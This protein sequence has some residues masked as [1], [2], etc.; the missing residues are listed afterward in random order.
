M[1]TRAPSQHVSVEEIRLSPEAEK[2]LSAACDLDIARRLL[3]A[4]PAHYV[5]LLIIVLSTPYYRDHP[6]LLTAFGIAI[7]VLTTTRMVLSALMPAHY[8]GNPQLWNTLIMAGIYVSGLLLSS[9]CFITLVYYQTQWTS[10]VL[11]VILSAVAAGSVSALTPKPR[12][13]RH[14]LLILLLPVISW[15]IA[16]GATE[17][18]AVSTFTSVF[19]AFL[20]LQSRAHCKTYRNDST[21]SFLLKTQAETVQ[22]TKEQLEKFIQQSLDPII[23]SDDTGHLIRVNRAF[24]DMIGCTEEEVIGKTTYDV[25]SVPEVGTYECTT[26]EKVTIDETYFTT[27]I[28]KI[29]QLFEDGVISNWISYYM[30]RFRKVV[31]V[32]QNIIFLYNEQGERTGAFS[33]IRNITEQRKAELE[34]IQAKEIA[35]KASQS[36]SNFLANM[37]HEIRTPMNGV[38]GF[39]DL[40]LE[41]SLSNEQKEYAGTIKNSGEALLKLIN[42]ILDFSKIE[43]GR[44]SFEAIDCDIE[45]LAYD[46]CELIRPKLAPAVEILCRIGD[47]LP[48]RVTC[49]PHRFRQVLL[50]LLGNAAKFT[51]AGEIELSLDVEEEQVD[52][53]KIHSK[54]RD[55]GI[56]I[57]ADNLTKIFDVFEQADSSTTRTYGGTGLGLAISRKIASIMDG[58]VWAEST[59]GKGSTFHFTS[60]VKKAEQP[61]ERKPLHISLA[62]KK[63]LL[64]DSSSTDLEILTH[65][66]QAAGMEVAGFKRGE[67]ALAAWED[68]LQSGNAFDIG[69]I[70][71]NMPDMSG[72]DLASKI[73]ALSEI[74]APLL[75]FA[76]AV[77]GEAHKC[78]ESGFNGFLPK[79]VNRRKLLQM[80]ERLLAE[81]TA[82]APG[83]EA[84]EEIK[85]QYS[86]QEDIKESISIL[87]AED[88]PVNQKLAVI[89]LTKA[90]YRIDVA[91]NGRVAVRKFQAE[92]DK[93]DIIFMDVQ[94]PE[95]DGLAATRQ[96]REWEIGLGTQDN[97]AVPATIPPAT[98]N[99]QPVTRHIPIVAMT[100]N[101]MKGDEE[102]CLEAG[103]NAYIAKPIKRDKIFEVLKK[104]VIDA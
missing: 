49:D 62:G 100:A 77:I 56:G 41:T 27:N 29:E 101:A 20:L 54:I 82:A 38:I 96:I 1:A 91:D 3:S 52:R 13:L 9:F 76:Y 8:S 34:L 7:I 42:D 28:K 5:L 93:Y 64:T 65:A 67:P 70:D 32:S 59:P 79:P 10:M 57:S 53:I 16:T 98:R 72:Y 12:L 68:A 47:T 26:G 89:L 95:M 51:H 30:T 23:I 90:G 94:M 69:V 4:A 99:P 81:A 50:N 48:A 45:V 83:R 17:S 33:I 40:L 85:T 46:I 6:V 25:F 84:G 18:Y 39:T 73:T 92:P 36:K 43:A 14:Y 66:L 102:K 22:E 63:I 15:G 97:E 103:M 37:S 21:K 87:L 74:H 75:A 86:V 11:L 35:E 71:I 24:L 60:W 55:T 88:N 78:R 58:E 104:F 19:L 61:H 2:E 80:M 31:P 44:I